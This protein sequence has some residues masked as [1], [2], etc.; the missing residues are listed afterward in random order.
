MQL[1]LDYLFA[2]TYTIWIVLLTLL[3]MFGLSIWLHHK[4][5]SIWFIT[6]SWVVLLGI[7]YLSVNSMIDEEKNQ[8]DAWE[9]HLRSLT[10]AFAEST[11][12]LGHWRLQP[13]PD[14]DKKLYEQI[15]RLHASW[16]RD[17]MFVAN[18]YTFRQTGPEEMEYVCNCESDVNMDGK[19]EGA[20]EVGGTLFTAYTQEGQPIW[21]ENYGKAFSGI[22]VIE[23]NFGGDGQDWIVSLAP[24]KDQNGQVESVFRVDFRKEDWDERAQ[25]LHA[26]EHSQLLFVVALTLGGIAFVGNLRN[27]LA[28]SRAYNEQMRQM[29]E[30]TRRADE[31]IRVM[32]NATPLGCKIWNEQFELEDCNDAVVP[33]FGVKSKEEFLER[34]TELMPECQP[35]GR[36]SDEL[37]V[38]FMREALEKG[39]K[40]A[41][42]MYRTLE[43]TPLPCEVTLVRVL[44]EETEVVAAYSRDLREI[45]KM[46]E[47]LA[48]E[49]AEL[50]R[51]KE[52][53]EKSA[54]AKSEFLANM[55]HEI[56]TPMNAI[57]G[58]TYLCLQTDLEKTQRD[59]LE[60]S[61]SAT[62]SL[63]RIID[64]ILDLSK[65]EAGKLGIE[66]IPFRLS[67]V[68]R[69]IRTFFRSRWKNEVLR[70]RPILAVMCRMI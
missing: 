43:G 35:C 32:F 24:L 13:G 64:D 45:K 21:G 18:A 25:K 36:R 44:H 50:R 12:E 47:E 17:L 29:Q 26:A 19:I 2:N 63:L 69:E 60:K 62:M 20:D 53:A 68:V 34:Y 49:Q 46:Q 51:A 59:Y 67:Q 5:S 41:E 30:A 22:A 61:Q 39:C 1:Y 70:C 66:E 28:A 15:M 11:Q 6:L 54:N 56:R 65:I 23:E 8:R 4:K 40:R 27:S 10:A 58:M 3:A 37:K 9:S 16:C 33:M 57:L 38:E 55:S 42:W 7:L 14:F 48:K 31:R 52:M